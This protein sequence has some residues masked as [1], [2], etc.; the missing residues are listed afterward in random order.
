MKVPFEQYSAAYRH[1]HMARQDGVIELR[2]HSD[3]G[4]LVWGDSPHTE[5]GYCFAD[6]GSDV[7]N[8]V[9]IMTGT[10]SEFCA[11]LDTSWVG[12]MTPAKWDKI[13]WHG[14][15]LLMNLLEIEAPVVAAVNGAA[16]VH[17]E[18]ALLSDIVVASD[19]AVFQD[20]PHFR[21]GAVPGDGVHVVWSAL[22]G[23]NRARYFLL[24]GQKITAP[25]ALDL[26]IVNEVVPAGDLV[27][28]AGELARDLARQSDS[29]LRYTRATFTQPLK[30]QL[31]DGLSYGLAFE[32]L[33]AFESWPKQAPQQP[34]TPGSAS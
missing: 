30:R 29:T 11:R 28:R 13:F 5:L 4:P 24:T 8:R 6:V 34:P 26:G 15:R 10:G 20:A 12:A 22:L 21:H 16:R 14:R 9:V 31:L 3:G 1:V 18:M 23:P 7:D 19:D 17:A 32:G 27:A 2:L 25:E 33:T